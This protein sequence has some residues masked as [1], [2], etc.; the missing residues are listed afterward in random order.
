MIIVYKAKYAATDMGDAVEQA[1][2]RWRTLIG[3]PQA[4]LPWGASFTITDENGAREVELSV[5]T[6]HDASAS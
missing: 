5:S 6:D 1:T 3:D 4:K 2:T